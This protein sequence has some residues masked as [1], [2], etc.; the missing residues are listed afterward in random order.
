MIPVHRFMDEKLNNKQLITIFEPFS[1]FVILG[2]LF[3]SHYY[4]MIALERQRNIL[5]SFIITFQPKLCIIIIEKRDVD[6]KTYVHHYSC[7]FFR[8]VY[9]IADYYTLFS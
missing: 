4:I 6:D 7:C 1:K 8:Y 2:P 3:Y 9:S 5:K